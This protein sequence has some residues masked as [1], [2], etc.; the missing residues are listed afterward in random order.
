[1]LRVLRY[2]ID[3]TN[4]TTLKYLYLINEKDKYRVLETRAFKSAFIITGCSGIFPEHSVINTN[5]AGSNCEAAGGRD[6]YD[7]I[8]IPIV[9]KN[10]KMN[11]HYKNK[12]VSSRKILKEIEKNIDSMEVFYNGMLYTPCTLCKHKFM[13]LSGG[14]TIIDERSKWCKLELAFGCQDILCC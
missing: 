9:I 11:D 12:L 3:Q 7:T 1:M 6:Y 14:C 5:P 8:V 10:L 13:G 4:D 2:S